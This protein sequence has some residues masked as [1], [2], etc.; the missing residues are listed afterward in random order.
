[1]LDSIS[2]RIE[3]CIKGD[4][5][6]H[7]NL[8]SATKIE[9]SCFWF[10]L[11]LL[12]SVSHTQHYSVKNNGPFTEIE[13]VDQIFKNFSLVEPSRLFEISVCCSCQHCWQKYINFFVHISLENRFCNFFL[14]PYFSRVNQFSILKCTVATIHLKHILS[15]KTGKLILY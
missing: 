9:Y 7:E 2:I 5:W 12:N 4:N 10:A 3:L 8:Y 1:L 6:I 15:P 11:F 13:I 14:F